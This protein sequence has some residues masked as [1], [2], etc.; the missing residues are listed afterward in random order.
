MNFAAETHVDRS[1]DDPESFLR[2]DI[3]GTHTLLE[4]V[5]ERGIGRMV[6]VSTD[7]VYG[8][9][10]SGSFCETDRINPSSPT[11][12]ARPAATCRCSRTTPPTARRRSS[13]AAP[14]PT[15]RTSTPRSSSRCSSPTRSRAGSCRST[16]TAST[17]ATGCTSTTTPTAS[18]PRCFRRAG[19]GLQHRRRQRAHQPRDHADHPRRAGAVAGTRPCSPSPT[20]PATTAATRSRATR[21]ARSWAGSRAVDFEAGLRETIRWYRDNE[22]W[23][24]KIKHQTEEFAD[25]RKRWYEERS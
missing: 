8:S 5:R 3:F 14:T 9:I 25:W 20:A 21:R 22:A 24:S 7:E 19:R 13:R 16:A 12:R 2:T 6:Q 18:R 4:A 11:R 10:D 1:I 23:W 15:A 17:C